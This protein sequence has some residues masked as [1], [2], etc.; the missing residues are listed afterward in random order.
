MAHNLR[1]PA[2]FGIRTERYKLLFFYGSSPLG[3]SKTPAAWELYD[4]ENDPGEMKNQFTNPEYRDIVVDLKQQPWE[5]RETL[6]ET[7]AK[8][9]EVQKIIDAHKAD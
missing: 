1:V 9:P 8:Y 5:T 7:D 2:H 6:N 4:L 3:E